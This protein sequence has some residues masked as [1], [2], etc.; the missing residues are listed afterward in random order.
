MKVLET[1]LQG[2]LILEIEPIADERG[3]FARTWDRRDLAS[4]GL[5]A[6]LDQVSIA[7]NEVAGTLRGLHFQAAPYG[8]AKT[9]RCTAGEIFD[10]AVDLRDGSPTRLRWVGAELSATNRRAL[11]VPEGCAHGYVT[12]TDR[13]EVQYQ[14]STPYRSDAARGYRWNDPTLAIDWPVPI[15]R[16]SARDAALPYVEGHGP[17]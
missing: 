5:T 12:L 16:I 1:I 2:V 17:A 11:F 6:D 15:R 3:F 14:M 10:V 13:A 7:Y 9:V 4:R 8:E